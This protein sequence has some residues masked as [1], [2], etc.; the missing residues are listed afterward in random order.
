[1]RELALLWWV[2]I[3]LSVAAL[4][5]MSV[6]VS[7]R[8]LRGRSDA[9]RAHDRGVASAAFLDAMNGEG[10]P[11]TLLVGLR[12]RARLMAET[13]L[14]AMALVRGVECDR[15]IS[16]LALIGVDGALRRRLSIGSLP[17]RMVA[18]EALANFP[19]PETVDA[20]RRALPRARDANL[21][22]A[23][24]R[25]LIEIDASPPLGEVLQDI[26]RSRGADSLLYLPLIGR[27]VNGDTSDALRAFGDPATPAAARIILAEALGA[28]GD[29]RALQPLCMI[30]AAP[31][32]E[33]RIA[34]VRGLAAMAHPAAE[35]H[36]LAALADPTWA[37]RSAACEA[38][39]R[40]GLQNA[41]PLLVKQLSDSVWWVRFRAGEA[42]AMLGQPGIDGLRQVALTGADRA[43][44]AASLALAERGLSAVPA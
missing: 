32:V 27:L 44:R 41:T 25:S 6:L 9:K 23:L 18:A 42:L 34:G 11:G 14:E 35:P 36:I 15:L 39:G 30:I 8:L 5:W 31:D 1:M 37:V 20:L 29:F 7:C 4:L 40:I 21:R 33:L 22:V 10:D 28:S 19:S 12:H 43:R 2:S 3:A 38:A 13:L 26:A 16:T 17:E 24:M